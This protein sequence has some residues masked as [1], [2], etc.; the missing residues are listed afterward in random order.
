[1]SLP[2]AALVITL[3]VTKGKIVPAVVAAVLTAIVF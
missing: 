3:I 1:M 2:V